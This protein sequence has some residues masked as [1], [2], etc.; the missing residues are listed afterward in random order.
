MK[1]NLT[2]KIALIFAVIVITIT[3]NAQ[4]SNNFEISKNLEIYATLFRELNKNYVDEISPGELMNTGIDAMLE[5]LDP[6]TVYISETEVEDIKFITTGQYGGIGA[7]IHKQNDYVVISEPYENNPAHQNGLIAGDII[8]EVDGKSMKD[9]STGDVS[10]L[11]KGQPG[12][13]VSLLVERAGF[14]EPI[15]FELERKNVKID[16]VPYY[17]MLNS[18]VGYIKLTGFTQEAGKEVKT[19]FMELRNDNELKGLILDLRGNGGGLL[20]EAVKITNIFV[21]KGEM[22]VS[23]K[24]KIAVK[25]HTYRT[26]QPALD[27]EIPLVVLVDN[28]SASASEIVAGALQDHDRAVIVGQTTFGK[29]LV[30]NVIPLAYNSQAKI[31]V[32][33]YYIPS[34]RCIQEIDYSHKNEN[35]DAAKVP[36]SLIMAF[37][38]RNGRVVYDGHGIDP[39]VEVDRAT[40]SDIGYTLVTDFLV[41]DFANQFVRENATI[42]PADEFEITADI[43]DDFVAFIN[44][45]GFDYS[46][47]VEESLEKFRKSAEKGEV[48]SDI[49][50]EFDAL[51]QKLNALKADDIE[52]NRE[53][54]S[55]VLKLEIVSR[56]YYQTG[57]IMATL[58]SDEEIAKALELMKEQESYAAILAGTVK[59]EAL[60][61]RN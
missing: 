55:L 30:Q 10:T 34:G 25:N 58:A 61:S 43:Y 17:G 29:G 22:V 44:E 5:S 42:P 1:T 47:R 18:D 11:L 38:T 31:T 2:N 20:Q 56:Y 27:T 48:F 4:N 51:S 19:A 8:L 49:E 41:F 23:T 3:A 57:K 14:D 24:G 35:G 52:K 16:N 21:D 54:I 39:D 46:T 28:S 13:M 33:K 45:K 26:T 12:T 40:M 53:E 15:A 9:K 60:D 50:A 6:Y 36:D 7:L 59:T 32:A 37:K